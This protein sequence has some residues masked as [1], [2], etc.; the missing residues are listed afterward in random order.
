[1]KF[2]PAVLTIISILLTQA[3]TAQTNQPAYDWK[4]ATSN[5]QGKQFPEVNSESRVRAY[6]TAPLAQSVQLDLGGVKYPLA[7]ETDGTWV[8]D[9]K[10]QA[11]GFHHYQ[12]IVD[13]AHVPD[14][15]S[16]YYYVAGRWGSAIEVRAKDQDFYALKNIP[17]GQLRQTLFY[18]KRAGKFLRCFV[19]TPPDYA[20]DPA[21]RYPVLYLQHGAGE[22]ETGWGSQ[23]RVGLIM[24]NL[25]A[26]GKVIPFIIAMANSYILGADMFGGTTDKT[27]TNSLSRTIAGPGGRKF[28]FNAFAAVLIDEL[29]PFIDVGFRTLANQPHHALAGLSIGGGQSLNFGL[30]HLDMFAW[31]GGFSSAPNT[32]ALEMLVPDP[33]KPPGCSSCS[34]FPAVITMD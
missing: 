20:Q 33:A 14:P 34:G 15:D 13:G 5:Q 6:V 10:P 27:M 21:K 3:G 28:N 29:I 16:L 7:R 8:G 11:E 12:I 24:D 17:H 26:E 2:K 19:Y 1:M 31:I 30:A 25:I 9:S 18:S 22:D 32:A 4:P 23:G